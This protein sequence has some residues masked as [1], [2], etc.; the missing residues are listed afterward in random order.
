MISFSTNT[1]W[2]QD[3][4]IGSSTQRLGTTRLALHEVET[5]VPDAESAIAVIVLS[6]II[7]SGF[8]LFAAQDFSHSPTRCRVNV[9]SSVGLI[10]LPLWVLNSASGTLTLIAPDL[11]GDPSTRL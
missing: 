3:L 7:V 4:E 8:A 10:Q 11:D 5:K 6:L 2:N 9:V 1:L